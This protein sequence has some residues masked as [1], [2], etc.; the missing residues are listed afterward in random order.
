MNGVYF[1]VNWGQCYVV[2][3]DTYLSLV[4]YTY[5]L[6][7]TPFVFKFGKMDLKFSYK[8]FSSF[9]RKNTQYPGERYTTTL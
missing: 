6:F 8:Y 3:L 4:L 2:N 7:A 1:S 9:M 5:Y